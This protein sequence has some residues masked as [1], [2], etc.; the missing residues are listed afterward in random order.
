MPDDDLES[1]FSKLEHEADRLREDVA[2]ACA[3]AALTDRDVAELRS[4]LRAHHRVLNAL[5]ETQLEQGQQIDEL[6]QEMHQKFGGLDRK[7][8]E[9]D[10]KMRE[11]FAIQSTG[12]AQITALLT[13]IAGSGRDGS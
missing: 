4:E 7:F 8:D 12:I 3:L 2:S 1:R 9:L 11:G 10:R 6:R 13:N 5:R